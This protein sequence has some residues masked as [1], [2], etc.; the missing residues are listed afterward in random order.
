MSN[1]FVEEN[2][3]TNIADK[4]RGK[5]DSE[6]TFKPSEMPDAIASIETPNLQEKTV[7]SNGDVTPDNGYNGLSKVTVRVPTGGGGSWSKDEIQIENGFTVNF[8]DLN[9]VLIETHS[10]KF[11]MW[12]DKPLSFDADSWQNENGYINSFPLT[13]T[14]DMGGTV[15]NLYAHRAERC[16]D[17]L[18]KFFNVDIGEYPY[19]LVGVASNKICAVFFAK[20]ATFSGDPLYMATL[21]GCKYKLNY[22]Y[23]TATDIMTVTKEIIQNGSVEFIEADTMTQGFFSTTGNWYDYVYTTSN[24]VGGVTG[25]LD[26]TVYTTE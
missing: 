21:N 15:Y 3:L 8:Y 9:S 1:V 7:T 16:S 19:L 4:I 11:G 17:V 14:E 2:T 13:V 10:A 20:T 24:V 23:V 6:S 5:L 26:K 18:Y 12:I 25:Y 22:F